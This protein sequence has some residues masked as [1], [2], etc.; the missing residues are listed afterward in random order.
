MASPH[1]TL[2]SLHRVSFLDPS[3]GKT[4]AAKLSTCRSAIVTVGLDRYS[5]PRRIFVLDAWAA[6]CPTH[7]L[8]DK[9]F[10]VFETWYPVQFGCEANAMQSLYADTLLMEAKRRHVPLP[11]VS[12]QQSTR[13]DKV[14]RIRTALQPVISSGSLFLR[15][16][17]VELIAE[18]KAFPSGHLKD[19][20]DAL[21]SAVTML[22][23]ET[24][25]ETYSDEA[26]AVARHLREI[27][28]S[29][30]FI[31]DQMQKIRAEALNTQ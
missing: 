2:Q 27:G 20:I 11:L 6:R 15:E 19:I 1:P 8:T 30:H 23:L 13:I 10:E 3:A 9:V 22:P 17:Q 4:G 5:T 7:K 14:F 24:L 28:A 31:Q 12:V 18:I 21:A 26:Q 29:P 25:R 16:D